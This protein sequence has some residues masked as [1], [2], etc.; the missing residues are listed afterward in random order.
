MPRTKIFV[1]YSHVDR[2]WQERLVTHLAVLERKG[3]LDIWAD[4]AIRIGEGWE[5]VVDDQL[6]LCRVAVLL[7]SANFLASPFI[8]DVEV[9]ELLERHE[10]DGLRLLPFIARPC[11]WQLVDWLARLQARPEGGRP[12]SHGTEPE[13]DRDLALL[14]YELATILGELNPGAAA[15]MAQL[16]SIPADSAGTLRQDLVGVPAAADPLVGR[17]W[18]GHYMAVAGGSRQ[19]M[20]LTVDAVDGVNLRGQIT[21]ADRAAITLITGTIL[22]PDEAQTNDWIEVRKRST[23]PRTC[24]RFTDVSQQGGARLELNGDYRAIVDADLTV[25][26]LWYQDDRAM[27]PIGEFDLSPA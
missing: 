10:R 13:I 6:K 25:V 11:A 12:L 21:W 26:G 4:T 2:Q 14:T 22:D 27:A 19:S 8:Q 23:S 17:S 18:V 1:S 5:R 7:I 20:R 24:I 3:L 9:K 16:A 15:D